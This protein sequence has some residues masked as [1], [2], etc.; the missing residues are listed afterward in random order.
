MSGGNLQHVIL[1]QAL[2]L[3]ANGFG[4]K[5]ENAYWKDKCGEWRFVYKRP[6]DWNKNGDNYVSAP[7]IALAVKLVRK[8]KGVIGWYGYNPWRKKWFYC[9]GFGEVSGDFDTPDQAEAALLDALLDEL[10]PK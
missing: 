7:T 8:V 5:V 2:R 4:W 3:R 6:G 9:I 1:G 10:S